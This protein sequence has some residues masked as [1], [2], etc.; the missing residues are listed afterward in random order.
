MRYLLLALRT[1]YASG[2]KEHWCDAATKTFLRLLLLSIK[3]YKYNRLRLFGRDLNNQPGHWDI[4]T[5]R[6]DA[7]DKGNVR[8]CTH[9][10]EGIYNGESEGWRG[11]GRRQ[12]VG[13]VIC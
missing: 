4:Q 9:D 13:L 6:R 5:M 10:R 8:H 3:I 11:F 7:R 12:R 2:G 1:K